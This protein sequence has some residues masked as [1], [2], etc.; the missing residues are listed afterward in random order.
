MFSNSS[1]MLLAQ[2]T[3]STLM[4]SNLIEFI[5]ATSAECNAAQFANASGTMAEIF[6]SSRVNKP[7]VNPQNR[8]FAFSEMRY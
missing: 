6:F 7:S 4:R 2:M 8:K 3:S 5:D 1:I